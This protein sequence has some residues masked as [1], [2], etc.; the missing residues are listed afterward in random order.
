[1]KL[2]V[3]QIDVAQNI[4][5]GTPPSMVFSAMEGP[6]W[7]IVDKPVKVHEDLHSDKITSLCQGD[8]VSCPLLPYVTPQDSV[9]LLG[10]VSQLSFAL[11]KLF[12]TANKMALGL[13]QPLESITLPD[14]SNAFRVWLGFAFSIPGK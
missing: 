2:S 12:P 14:G 5:Q 11:G 3:H 6:R 4:Q 10:F 1:M 13:G 9:L 7:I 8:Y